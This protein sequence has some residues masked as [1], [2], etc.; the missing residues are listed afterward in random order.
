MRDFFTSGSAAAQWLEEKSFRSCRLW[1]TWAKCPICCLS[2]FS[3][4]GKGNIFV[5]TVCMCSTCKTDYVWACLSVNHWTYFWWN[6]QEIIC[7]CSKSFWSST[8]GDQFVNDFQWEYTRCLGFS[9]PSNK[10]LQ[11]LLLE[12]GTCSEN[13]CNILALFPNNWKVVEDISKNF[14]IYNFGTLSKFR[15]RFLRRT[16]PR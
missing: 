6:F 2:D 14:S 9:V 10:L 12:F 13:M 7:G 8:V 16:R 11:V 1:V 15:G 5:Y 4:H 3:K